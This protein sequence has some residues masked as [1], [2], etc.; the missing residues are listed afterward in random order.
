MA[1]SWT[2][3]MLNWA[4]AGIGCAVADGA[5][6]PL[7]IIKVR[8]QAKSGPN[9]ALSVANVFR[10][11]E[12]TVKTEGMRGLLVPGLLPTSETA[13]LKM[14][15]AWWFP[16][17]SWSRLPTIRIWVARAVNFEPNAGLSY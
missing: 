1:D 12:K 3:L 16:W 17:A 6:N 2:P 9:A 13:S 5:M 8:M 10:V 15:G 7:E 11:G 4:S 14:L